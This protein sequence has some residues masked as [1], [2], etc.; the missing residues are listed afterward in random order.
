MLRPTTLRATQLRGWPLSLLLLTLAV[1]PAAFAAEVPSADDLLAASIAH[2][3][4]DGHFLSEAWCLSLEET[5]PGGPDRQ[6]ELLI[7]VPGERFELD[8]RT[9]HHT[10]GILDGER[11]EW[12]L[13]G[14]GDITDAEREEHRL[15]C[16]RLRTM[17]DYYTYL[18]GL[19]MK[20]RDPGTQL[21]AVEE[22]TFQ[23]RPVHG[24]RVTYAEE[25]GSDTWYF[26]FDCESH[27]LVG[28]R[29]YHDEAANDGEYVALDGELEATS[30]QGRGPR[31][32]ARRAWYTHGDERHL[33][34]DVLVALEPCPR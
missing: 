2:H 8:R 27:A 12:T 28:Y 7:D 4:P 21:G 1:C 5:R 15:T 24:L 3:D 14:R 10:T 32:P 29:F 22:T 18:W 20:L 31:L 33:G 13:D 23:D 25:V 26:Y 6:T 19:P 16:D 34:T 9:D 17:R 30:S 11:C